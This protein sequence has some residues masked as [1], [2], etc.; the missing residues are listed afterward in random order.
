MDRMLKRRKKTSVFKN[1]RLLDSVW[2]EE[3][4]TLRS[5]DADGNENIKKKKKKKKKDLLRKKELKKQKKRTEKK[6]KK[7][8]KKKKNRFD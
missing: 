6:K 3:I 8:K 5:N 4:G 7:K 2:D 1:T